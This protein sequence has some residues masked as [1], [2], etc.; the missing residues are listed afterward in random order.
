MS[1]FKVEN[2]SKEKAVINLIMHFGSATFGIVSCLPKLA[3]YFGRFSLSNKREGAQNIYGRERESRS[4]FD[5]KTRHR[6]RQDRQK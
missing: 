6:V 4:G 3:I 5:N 2:G 1:L